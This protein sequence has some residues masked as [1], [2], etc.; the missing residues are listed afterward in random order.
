MS[1]ISI[2]TINYN[3]ALATLKMVESVR[4]KSSQDFEIIIVDNNSEYDDFEKLLILNGIDNIKIVRSRLNLGFSGGNMLGVQRASDESS[5]YLF[6]NNDT[7]I[8][9]DV[10]GMLRGVCEADAE[11]GLVSAQQYNEDN[12]MI[13]SFGV[14]P[15]IA[16]K[17]LGKWLARALSVTKIYNSKK[18]YNHLITVGVHSN[19]RIHIYPFCYMCW[20]FQNFH[21]GTAKLLHYCGKSTK[22]GYEIERE[23]LISYFR[24]LNKHLPIFERGILKTLF[25]IKYLK[26]TIKNKNNIRL[27]LFIL[28]TNKSRHSLRYTQKMANK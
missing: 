23:F 5:Y 20:I 15:N 9:N 16:E 18:V 21:I 10:L 1:K 6:L 24:L 13:S 17:V 14:F 25:F 7:V 27:L 22:R 2:I 4:Q 12:K 3:S 19:F 26:K 8:L 28:N 11:I